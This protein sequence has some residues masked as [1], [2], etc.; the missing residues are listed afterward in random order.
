MFRAR[1]ESSAMLESRVLLSHSLVD[2]RIELVA[3]DPRGHS[4]ARHHSYTPEA[5]EVTRKEAS[6]GNFAGRYRAPSFSCPPGPVQ[7]SAIT[8]PGLRRAEHGIFVLSSH[9]QV[10]AES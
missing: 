9:A 8:V 5:G 10:E 2:F 6:S 1:P 7:P 3:H 4:K